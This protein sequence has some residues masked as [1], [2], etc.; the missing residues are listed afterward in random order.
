MITYYKKLYIKTVDNLCEAIYCSLSEI[1]AKQNSLS[2]YFD[3]PSLQI[4]IIIKF[5]SGLTITMNIE[6][7]EYIDLLDLRCASEWDYGQFIS[8]VKDNI[9]EAILKN[10]IR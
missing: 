5:V 6:R 1:L 10:Y 7:E 9:K 4:R 8:M 2:V 3:A